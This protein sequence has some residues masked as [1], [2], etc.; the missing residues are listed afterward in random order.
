[1]NRN[2]LQN[3]K[4]QN[5]VHTVKTPIKTAAI[6]SCPVSD[7]LCT[8]LLSLYTQQH[9]THNLTDCLPVEADKT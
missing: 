5:D 3:L 8:N 4:L 9:A 7:L 6:T 1:M 2:I